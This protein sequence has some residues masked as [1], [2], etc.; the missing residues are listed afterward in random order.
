MTRWRCA[1]AA[2]G[3]LVFLVL[4]P[5]YTTPAFGFERG[6]LRERLEQRRQ[7]RE[8]APAPGDVSGLERHTLVSGGVTRSYDLFVPPQAGN[9][10]LPLVVV[11]HGGH[12]TPEKIAQTTQM[13]ELARR[14]GFF[15]AYPAA[16]DT[17]RV[18]NDGRSTTVSEVDDVAFVDAMLAEIRAKHAVDAARIFA[19]G[20]SNGGM[21]TLRLA[22]ERA[23]VF[24]AFAPVVANLPV[25][26]VG[27]CQP[28][29]PVPILLI[30]GTE[31]RLMPW[32]GGEVAGSRL[33]GRGKGSVISSPE[34][35]RFF[36]RNNGCAV[37]PIVEPL[38]DRVPD[39]GTRVE[40]DRFEGCRSGAPVI[41]YRVVGGGHTWPGSPV[42]PTLRKSGVT[43]REISATEQIWQFFRSV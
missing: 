13:H 23:A 41:A 4:V 26:M 30:Q 37:A 40:V 43:S 2:V 42:D 5:V 17:D 9:R 24:R 14:E 28:G 19:T 12:S 31:D 20:A 38:P 6:A 22:C 15:V 21:F 27:R 11:F 8:E 16:I 18:W 39:D 25:D 7:S 35:V 10:P 33:L 36:A 1:R 3:L 34:T 29:R 32:A